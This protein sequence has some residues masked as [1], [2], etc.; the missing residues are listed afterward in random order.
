LE[1]R[2]KENYWEESV[3]LRLVA[4]NYLNRGNVKKAKEMQEKLNKLDE[5]NTSFI[6]DS[7][8]KIRTGRLKEAEDIL[9]EELKEDVENEKNVG[10]AHRETILLL[11]IIAS[12]EGKSDKALEYAKT[13]LKKS[14]N[15]DSLFTQ[16]VAHMRLGHAL[17]INGAE[18]QKRALK[19]YEKSLEISG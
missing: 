5:E 19:A 1:L 11:S 8:V 18:K 14:K 6:L 4:E 15:L 3:L 9:K 13:G 16:A 12:F 17:Q 10:R 7:R 2:E